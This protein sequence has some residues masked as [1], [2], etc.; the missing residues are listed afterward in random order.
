[1]ASAIRGKRGQSFLKEMLAALDALPAKRLIRNELQDEYEHN[2]VC[3]LG[4][5]GRARRLPMDTVDPYDHES[6][7]SLF[8]IP[9]ALASEVMFMNDDAWWRL[10]PD[11]LFTKMRGWVESQITPEDMSDIDRWADDGGAR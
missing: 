5:V 11:E 2:A 6:V 8:G 9:H 10:P 1:M 3:A 7:A 4:A